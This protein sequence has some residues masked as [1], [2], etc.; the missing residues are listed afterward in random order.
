MQY[1][2]DIITQRFTLLSTQAVANAQIVLL[3][4]P[5]QLVAVTN[6]PPWQVLIYDVLMRGITARGT[7]VIAPDQPTHLTALEQWL[8]WNNNSTLYRA[9]LDR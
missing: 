8:I 1:Q 3:T 5:T 6:R 4:N 9:Q 7:S 2:L